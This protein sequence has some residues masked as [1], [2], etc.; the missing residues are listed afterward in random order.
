M[1]NRKLVGK[2]KKEDLKLNYGGVYNSCFTIVVAA[3]SIH[4]GGFPHRA[5]KE[6]V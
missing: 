3:F 4:F 6:N 2:I 1:E 5:M